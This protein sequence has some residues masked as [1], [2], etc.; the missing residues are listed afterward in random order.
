[1][2]LSR[3]NR[4]ILQ[5]HSK[6]FYGAWLLLN[7]VQSAA[8]GLTDDEAYY[9]VYS[10]FPDWGYFDHPPMVAL[11]IKAGYS[12]FP[13]ELGV[14][15]LFAIMSTIAI[16]MIEK[17]LPFK[18]PLL[19]YT[20]MLAMGVLQLGGI[21]AIPD[22]PLIFFTVLYFFIYKKLVEKP[23]FSVA[24][25]LGV[26]IAL[27]L[28][29]KYHGVLIVFFT[30][31]AN[32]KLF[33]RYHIYIAGITAL[34]LLGP[35]L[36]WQYTHGFPSIQF[37]LLERNAPEYKLSFT[38]DYILGQIILAGPVAGPIFL[39]CTFRK[40]AVSA[41]ER[42]LKFTA[43]GFYLFFLLTTFKGRVE[44][45]WTIPAFIPMIVL[46][47]QYLLVN[48]NL[49]KWMTRL[50]AVTIILV[51][52]V[53]LHTIID[54][55]PR[56]Q[57]KIDEFLSNQEWAAA[58][59]QQAKGLPVFFTDSYQRPSKYWFY[60]GEPAFSLN[61]VD[62]RRNNFNFWIME[63]SLFNKRA[64][65]IY[66]GKK[67]AY[68][69][70]SIQTAKGVYLG[71]TIENY[72]SFSRIRIM[73]QTKLSA[74]QGGEVNTSLKIV[75]DEGMLQRIKSPYDTLPILLTVYEKDSVIANIPTNLRL[76][77]V[78]D[79]E[80]LLPARFN[81]NL[82]AGKY[83]TRFSITSCIENWPTINSTVI[84]LKVE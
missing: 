10:R 35:H 8:T 18:E 33:T 34:L 40:K 45:N 49:R 16:W 72:F 69:R 82:P 48:F 11:L 66:Q 27:L 9:W 63:D 57:F 62:Y 37:H 32:L 65:A 47:H 28:Y 29:S 61:T 3:I 24:V 26:T 83:V 17:L 25:L 21:I 75:A 19:F 74:T 42:S 44:A 70:D 67:A 36:Y 23:G 15:L 41:Y 5:N 78:N 58:I 30:L 13:N 71:R 80:V 22:T 6:I 14:R 12:I 52:V 59:Q 64:Y 76:G 68:Y 77:M 31:L 38:T 73:P 7:L 54:F 84:G 46:T 53:R 43:I 1:M 79:K 55:F 60:T 56:Q 51:F 2:D 81:V 4:L 20:L 39:W 50:A